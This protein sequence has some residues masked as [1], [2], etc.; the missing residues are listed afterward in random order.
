MLSQASKGNLSFPPFIFKK[1][2]NFLA[3]Y[4]TGLW[5]KWGN[6]CP[7][8]QKVMGIIDIMETQGIWEAMANFL[9][10]VFAKIV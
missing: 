3:A 4:T 2:F 5:V 9:A 6:S 10:L 7:H 1:M 8:Y